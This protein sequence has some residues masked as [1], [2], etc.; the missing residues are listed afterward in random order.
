MSVRNE[1]GTNWVNAF[2][3]PRL[4]T[5]LTPVPHSELHYSVLDSNPQEATGD[6]TPAL[7]SLLGD[8]PVCR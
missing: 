3:T 4:D 6:G 2:G 1:F 5:G 8:K 7:H